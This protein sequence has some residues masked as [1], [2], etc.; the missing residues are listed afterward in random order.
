VSIDGV[1]KEIND[2]TGDINYAGLFASRNTT[3]TY[4][5]VRLEIGETDLKMKLGHLISRAKAISNEDEVYTE[6]SF[7]TVQEAINVAEVVYQTTDSEETDVLMV[8]ITALQEAIDGLEK[9]VVE[10][11][12]PLGI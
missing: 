8:S 2:Y 6:S 9:K 5:N 3:V 1:T 7:A 10:P 11:N 4:S 12:P